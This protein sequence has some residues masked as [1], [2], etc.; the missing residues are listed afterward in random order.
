MNRLKYKLLII[1]ACSLQ[2]AISNVFAQNE[3]ITN[4]ISSQAVTVNEE[5][6]AEIPQVALSEEAKPV[7][8]LPELV[9]LARNAKD[10]GD[11]KAV[12]DYVDQ[13]MMRF[14]EKALA[15]QK[16]LKDF[17]SSDR[18][19]DFEALNYLAQCQF[20]KAEAL[21]NEGKKDQAIAAFKVIIADF[22]YAQAWDPR[23]WFYKL[24][25]TAQEGIDRLEGRDVEAEKCGT[26]PTTNIELYEPGKEEIVNYAA[27]G[28][29]S[30]IGTKDYKYTI[31]D[32]EKLSNAV[33][34]GIYPNT[35]SVRW[36]PQL[37]IV[38][39]E[40]RLE[41]SHWDFVH[42]PD[43]QAAFI[44]WALAPEPPGI[45]LYYT[46]L[47]LEKSGLIKHAIKAYYAI[48]VHYP[49]TV[50]WT[51]WHTPWY[52]GPAAISRIKYLCKKYPQANMNLV[53][54][55]ISIEN[56]FD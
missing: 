50:G 8:T 4:E 48:I 52:F 37:Q 19:A 38:K 16:S 56:G 43:I 28:D 32:Q 9:V 49:N 40:K 23:G 7:P 41:G 51:Y 6:P 54:A 36:D 1:L 47:I 55:K 53:G 14:K 24:A 26:T 46:G 21:K 10:K 30:G 12:Y 31:K 33:G 35:T 18:I 25:K 27:Y 44:K 34:E 15:E 11:Y 13:A 42:S 22:S 3:T 17:P 45:R 20:I 2:F 5:V 39:K 29:F